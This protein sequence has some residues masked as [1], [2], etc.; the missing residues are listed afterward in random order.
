MTVTQQN[1]P[2]NPSASRIIIAEDDTDLRNSLVKYL[3]L[4][5]YDVTGVGSALEC[6]QH[7]SESA[8][9]IAILDIGLPDQNGLVL[10]EY[11][12]N[13]TDMRIIILTARSTID[14]K[15]HGY[16]AGADVFIVKPVDVRELAATVSSLLGRAQ[17]EHNPASSQPS[18]TRDRQKKPV[19]PEES[20]LQA[21][22]VPAN[23]PDRACWK[24]IDSK[25]LLRSPNGRNIRLTVKEC[26]LMIILA[27]GN[28]VVSTR[29]ELMNQLEY[30]NNESGYRALESL[31]HRLRRKIKEFYPNAPIQT[32]QG[33]GYCFAEDIVIE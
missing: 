27:S 15:L 30:I 7:V 20:A 17:H 19:F 5:G 11:L 18:Q 28:R 1:S 8:Y 32:A 6:Y 16:D 12:R 31:I 25:W 3:A 2:H 33:V 23:N 21:E 4:R 14:D 22:P 24:L 26:K 29:T 10:T 13:N 9:K